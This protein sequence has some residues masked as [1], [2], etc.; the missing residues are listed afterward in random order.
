MGLGR[1]LNFDSGAL[2]KAGI[3][4]EKEKIVLNEKLQTTNKRIFV[5]GDAADNLKFSHAA[6]MHN[7][8]LI[9]NF[10]SPIKKKLDFKHFP[11][12]TFTDPEVA[13]FG[14]NKNQLK[15]Q[16]TKYIRLETNL[17][18]DDRAI[19]DDYEYGNL[20]VFIEK[21]RFN[22]GSA[23]I[24]GGSMIAP[25][26]GE[27]TQELMLANTAGIKLNAFINKIYPYPTAANIHK[28]LFIKKVVEKLKPWMKTIIKKW[29][30]FKT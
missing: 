12:V 19:T 15:K 16:N 29:Y 7:M 2:E 4:T 26:A 18:K 1:T 17:K 3:K 6:E 24:L 20:I 30:R 5:S 25:N 28:S 13:T 14:L 22:L 27:I 8:L 10:I 21:K 9:N 23:K 11:W